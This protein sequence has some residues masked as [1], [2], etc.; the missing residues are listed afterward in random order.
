VYKSCRLPPS[1]HGSLS[2]AQSHA[3]FER[4]IDALMLK[5]LRG[6]EISSWD[7]EGIL[8]ETC[9]NPPLGL[10]ELLAR[11]LVLTFPERAEKDENLGSRIENTFQDCAG[12]YRL[13][14]PANIAREN[15]GA[16]SSLRK[17]FLVYVYPEELPWGIDFLNLE[18]WPWYHPAG[19]EKEDTKSFPELYASSVGAA[20]DSLT[21]IFGKYLEEG[22]FPINEAAWAIGNGGLSIADGAGKPCAPN[23]SDPLPLDEVLEQQAKLRGL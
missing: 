3:F 5:H 19:E 4:I 2:F 1:K 6:E 18:H 23:R 22:R 7:Q 21:G 13:S 9:A 17:D 16:A 12:F 10:R 15:I 8:A 11:A 14:S 20:A